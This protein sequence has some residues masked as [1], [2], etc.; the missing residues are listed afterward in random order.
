[1]LTLYEQ[2]FA[3]EANNAARNSKVMAAIGP[4]GR[5]HVSTKK[6]T[7]M[8]AVIIATP[9]RLQ[10]LLPVL[11]STRSA[12]S[13][14]AKLPSTTPRNGMLVNSPASFGSTWKAF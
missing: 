10:R 1:M 7:P 11:A 6:T 2:G 13:P 14:P 5:S 12:R 9:L 8:A 4:S 3:P